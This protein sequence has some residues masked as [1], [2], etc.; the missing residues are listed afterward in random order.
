MQSVRLMKKGSENSIKSLVFEI[1][2][3]IFRSVKESYPANW[4]E[5]SINESLLREISQIFNGK[6]IQIPGNTVRTECSIYKLKD[7]SDAAADIGIAARIA[8]HD[9]KSVEGAAFLCAAKKD[10]DK[11]SFSSI[12]KDHVKK[13]TGIAHHSQI[14]L[15]DYDSISGLAFPTSPD[16]IIGGFPHTW[17]N[18]LPFTNACT[19]QSNLAIALGEKTSGLYKISVPLSYQ[20]CFRYLFGLDLDYTGNALETVTGNKNGKGNPKH[21]AVLTVS[22]S[23]AAAEHEMSVNRDLYYK[24]S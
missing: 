12:K 22:F 5:S 6:K 19:A 21:L 18:W 4:D 14:L 8:Y 11:N 13:L 1:E 17:N 2:E 15:Y 20:I 10:P 9:G 3:S 7:D 24:I 16:A 23:G